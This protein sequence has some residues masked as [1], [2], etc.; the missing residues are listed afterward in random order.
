[1]NREFSIEAGFQIVI[2]FLR[3]LWWDFLK[4]VMVKNGV[5]DSKINQS[6]DKEGILKRVLPKDDLHFDNGFFFLTVC[7][8]ISC[9]DYFEEVIEK[10]MHI[11]PMKQHD[12]LIVKEDMLFQLTIDFCDY[13]NKRYQKYGKDSLRFAINCLEDMRKNTKAHKIEWDLWNQTVIEVT[14]QNR[15]SLGFFS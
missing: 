14:E 7:N 15:K 10:R 2:L 11:P 5:I 1:M 8:G 13:F 9:D 12:G 3:D 4:D 6:R